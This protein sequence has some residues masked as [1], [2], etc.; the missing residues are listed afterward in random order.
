MRK[1]FGVKLA[2]SAVALAFGLSA[3]ACGPR[4][5]RAD[6]LAPSITEQ[7]LDELS[8]QRVADLAAMRD[9]LEAYYAE[10]QR[11]PGTPNGGFQSVATVGEAWIPELAPKYI[12]AL[13]RDP[14]GSQEQRTQYWYASNGGGRYKLI[15]HGVDACGP[16]FERQ[17]IRRDPART[18]R[19]GSCWAYGYFPDELGAY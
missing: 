14:A 3:I 6:E 19:D 7:P 2:A 1:V 8:T 11:Y 16:E 12:A 18:R 4:T 5:D 10:H 9:A 17:G 13:P 15:A